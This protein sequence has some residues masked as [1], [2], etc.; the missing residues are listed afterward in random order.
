MS[1]AAAKQT[2]TS[3]GNGFAGIID[4]VQNLGEDKKAG[5]NILQWTRTGE[6]IMPTSCELWQLLP[7]IKKLP[8]NVE[9]SKKKVLTCD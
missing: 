6:D 8:E 1:Q 7:E 9:K 4:G 2:L 3:A 5:R